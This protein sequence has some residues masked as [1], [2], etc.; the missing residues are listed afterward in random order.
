MTIDVLAPYLAAP[1]LHLDLSPGPRP[2]VADR[3]AAVDADPAQCFA[4][5]VAACIGE[6]EHVAV[7][8]TG[9]LSSQVLV[10]HVGRQCQ[11]EGR[12]LHII[13]ADGLD[14]SGVSLA[15][16]ALPVLTALALGH[17][18]VPVEPDRSFRPAPIGWG[19]P[20]PDLRQTR[21]VVRGCMLATD[22]GATA[23]LS[24]EGGDQLLRAPRFLG[25]RLPLSIRRYLRDTGTAG[26]HGELVAILGRLGPRR[27]ASS[28]LLAASSLAAAARLPFAALT[29]EAGKVARSW[30]AAWIGDA[31]AV[32]MRTDPA[33]AESVLLR[34]AA[35]SG[36]RRT[37]SA[38]RALLPRALP[39]HD[40]MM[41]NLS[42][43]STLAD[44]YDAR[45]PSAFQRS[46]ALLVRLVP[47]SL[48][49]YLPLSATAPVTPT[50]P[51]PQAFPRCAA[52][53]LI[54]APTPPEGTEP[55]L[56]GRLA[57]LEDWLADA[58][59]HTGA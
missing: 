16:Q 35:I 54:G 52:I 51:G 34:Q 58:E 43:G 17:F 12:R 42:V 47:A 53:G 29:A 8:Y 38:G 4:R 40:P 44:R 26:V 27:W 20:Q 57:L 22:L 46:R 45:L 9:D 15:A 10:A 39:F 36:P 25:R 6:Q 59:Q 28:L 32:F 41:L 5:A 49:Q 33:T 11:R 24:P 18:V 30:T 14:S 21:F 37:A 2:P 55:V 23:V 31:L 7:L 48:R 3:C 50:P 56:L 13:V 19:G 1:S